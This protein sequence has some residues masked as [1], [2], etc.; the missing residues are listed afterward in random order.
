M[1]QQVAF[2]RGINV[3]TAKRVAM[4]DLQ[5]LVTSL[6]YRDVRTLLNS[7]NVLFTVPASFQS[8]AA[9]RIHEGLKSQ[10]GV[11]AS[12]I[13]MTAEELA[14]I[15]AE[16]PL[17][18]IADHP[19][20]SLVAFVPKAEDLSNLASLAA[21]DWAPEAVA[22]GRRAVYLWCA[23]SVHQSKLLQ[24]VDRALSKAATTRNWFTVLKLGAL[25][26]SRD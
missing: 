6:G 21:K 7:G 5:A 4:K 3:G 8:D 25:L 26:A 10:L 9:A 19:S 11:T 20:R 16:N 15:I 2:I 18:S 23:E 14:E 13:V 22:I 1:S 17:A 12:V 24:A